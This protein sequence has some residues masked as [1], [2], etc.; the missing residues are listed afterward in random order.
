VK[1][2]DY[3]G[4]P[5]PNAN[6]RL[7]GPD[8]TPQSEI[9][10]ADGI[11]TFNGAIGGDIQVVAYLAEDDSYYE[12]RIVHVESPTL[13]EI[14]MGRYVV[15]GGFFVQTSLFLTIIIILP[16][17][18]IF[19]FWEAFRRIKS[20]PQKAAATVGNAGSK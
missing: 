8:E 6:V 15:L 19:L 4:Q 7:T 11:A 3:F 16:I 20:K 10:Q 5:I 9:T 2:G 12:A 14:R 13:I 17:V 18:A 1:V